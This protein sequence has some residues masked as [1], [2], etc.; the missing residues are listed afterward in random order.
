M[1]GTHKY[2]TISFHISPIEREEIEAK[3]LA[4]GIKKKD[5]SVRSCIYNRVCVV[6]V[7]SNF[8]N[9]RRA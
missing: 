7:E 8:L 4:S 9:V 1:S 2:Q 5:Y 3:T 6:Y